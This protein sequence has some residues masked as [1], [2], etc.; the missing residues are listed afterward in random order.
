MVDGRLRVVVSEF[1]SSTP[2]KGRKKCF[3]RF[4]KSLFHSELGRPSYRLGAVLGRWIDYITYVPLELIAIQNNPI[5]GLLSRRRQ[6]RARVSV[7]CENAP[8][9]RKKVQECQGK[10]T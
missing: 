6:T 10:K 2:E 5:V 8:Q 1:A 7:D 9:K 3:I 4:P